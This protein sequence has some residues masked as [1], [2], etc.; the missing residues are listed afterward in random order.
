[1]GIYRTKYNP[2][3]KSLQWVLKG[4]LITFKE[5]VSTYNNLPVTGN[6]QNEARI[7]DDTGHLY[8]WSIEESSGELTDWVDQGDVID[9]QWN[10]IEGKPSSTPTNIDD[11]VDKKHTQNTD[12]KLDE[13][14]ANEVVVSDIKDSVDKSHSQNSDTK[15]DEGGSDEI[16]AEELRI[17]IN[18]T[19]LLAFYRAV[20]NSK[21]IYGLDNTFMDEFEDESGIDTISSINEEYNSADDYYTPTGGIS[22][23]T[24][25]LLNCDGADEST[26]FTD[27]SDSG[28][29]VTAHADAQLDTA[30]KKWGTA[31]GLF[32]GTGD[33]L[34]IPDS[35]DW[36]VFGSNT[37]DWTIDMWIKLANPEVGNILMCHYQDDVTSWQLTSS[38]L[39]GGNYGIRFKVTGLFDSGY[40]TG[41]VSDTNWHHIAMCK[42]ADEYGVYLDGVQLI[43]ATSANTNT[44]NG[45]LNIGSESG[46]GA[47]FGGHMDEIRIIQANP[48]N[49]TP[50]VG[51]TDTITVPIKAYGEFDDLTLISNTGQTADLAPDNA[52]IILFEE[53]VDAIT[54]NTDLKAY[55][56]RDGGST[57]AEAT[58]I[59][60]GKFQGNK[61][62]LSALVDLTGIDSGTDI[63]YKVLSYNEKNLK[64]HAVGMS[65]S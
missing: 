60:D 30:E 32:D 18:N 36:D 61:R 7:T 11:A 64:L 23:N 53:D 37:D 3:S 5:S 15:L 54:L 52:R 9:L 24:K 50:N 42:V 34:S 44:F 25:L 49:A 27:S 6:S 56:S 22:S 48:F 33:Y 20:D 39:G 10:S 1:M 51:K 19:M 12:T 62:V 29:T 46:A 16:S 14:G 58:L 40:V 65:W 21:T 8:V 41:F 26:V 47:W 31:S 35:A 57:Y 2:F 28:H 17:N 38:G 13:G 55:V 63:E 43:Y 4:T 45:F 59:D